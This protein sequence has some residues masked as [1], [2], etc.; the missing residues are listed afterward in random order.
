[1]FNEKGFEESLGKSKEDFEK[2]TY[3]QQLADLSIYYIKANQL[4]NEFQQNKR[5]GIE[6]DIEARKRLSKNNK[7]I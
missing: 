3:E 5:K 1:M 7:M 2:Q 6:E 4:E